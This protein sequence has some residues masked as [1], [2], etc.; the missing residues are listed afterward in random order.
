ERAIVDLRKLQAYCLSSEHPRGRNK[1]PV[2]ASVGIRESDA[3]GLRGVL[4][5]IASDSEAR[6]GVANPYGQ[7]Y[8]IDFDLVRLGRT[9]RIRST[10]IVFTGEDLPRLTSCYVL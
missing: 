8:I 3:E 9:V 2:F 6:L 1:A 10:W 7:R 5:G 4:L